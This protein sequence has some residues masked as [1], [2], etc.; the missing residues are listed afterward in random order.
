MHKQVLLLLLHSYIIMKA[1]IQDIFSS[2]KVTKEESEYFHPWGIYDEYLYEHILNK[3]ETSNKKEM[4]L[5]LSTNNHPPYNIPNGYKSK[6]LNYSEDLKNHIIGD[7][8]LAKQRFK[9]Y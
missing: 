7:F 1:T 3:L 8:D 4:I 5:A 2:I 9:S 6:I